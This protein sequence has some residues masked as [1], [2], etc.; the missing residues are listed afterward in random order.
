MRMTTQSI[1]LLRSR[2]A[3]RPRS[4]GGMSSLDL[5]VTFTLLVAVMSILSPL[6]VRHGRLLQSHRDYRLAL[7]ELSNQAERLTSLSLEQLPVAVEQLAPSD[8]VA[9][10]LPG[11]ELV[12]EL[13]PAEAGVRVTLRIAWN[14][15]ERRR[16][17]VA[18]AVWV[19][20]QPQSPPV[21]PTEDLP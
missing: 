17:P 12:G 4:R 18:L 7:D 6:T 1:I 11:A 3:P 8:F 19:F 16:A 14:S 5:L 2:F 15:P 13:H 10:R 21:D 20:P 9:E